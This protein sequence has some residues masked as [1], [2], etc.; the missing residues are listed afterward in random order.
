MCPQLYWVF[1]KRLLVKFPPCT[2]NR[3]A[4]YQKQTN[5]ETTP[6]PE[7]NK[8][9]QGCGEM[10]IYR[11]LV[12]QDFPMVPSLYKILWSSLESWKQKTACDRLGI[13]PRSYFLELKALQ[14]LTG[15]FGRST[16]WFFS[17]VHRCSMSNSSRMKL[18]ISASILDLLPLLTLVYLSVQLFPEK[19]IF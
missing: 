18:G 17:W 13:H 19:F 2:M 3:K 9:W 14:G 15:S 10:N 4:T 11:Q 8:C 5:K 16:H 1:P 7:N 6:A 12:W